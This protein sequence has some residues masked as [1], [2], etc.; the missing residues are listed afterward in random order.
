MSLSLLKSGHVTASALGTGVGV[1]A[2]GPFKSRVSLRSLVSCLSGTGALLVFRAGC[3]G[4]HLSDAGLITQGAGVGL[5]PFTPQGEAPDFE[6]PA[7]HW[8]LPWG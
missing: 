4:A 3:L 6:F 7:G 2:Y 1:S 5:E 8:S